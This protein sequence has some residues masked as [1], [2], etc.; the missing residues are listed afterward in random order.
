MK[1]PGLLVAIAVVVILVGGALLKGFG[2]QTT[3]DPT[4]SVDNGAPRGFLALALLLRAQGRTV[5]VV[6][7]FDE[8]VTPAPG[9]VVLV[10]PPEKSA[11]T[12]REA[13]DLLAHVNRGAHVVIACD[14]EEQR[15][16]NLK[17]LAVA[18][19]IECRRAD[20]AIGDEASKRAVAALPGAP[21][22][23]SVRGTGRVRPR[24]GSPAF[25]AWSA[26]A[27]AVVVKRPLGQGSVT[28]L[29]SATIFA[30][31][32]LAHDAN[33]AFAMRELAPSI[34]QEVSA[35]G[36]VTTHTGRVVV[37]E[38]HHR[39][40]SRAA[41]LS[42]AAKGWGPWTALAGLALLVPLSLLMLVPRAGDAPRVEEERRGA[43]A[44]EAQAR[45]LAALLVHASLP[46]ARDGEH[47][48]VDPGAP[49][50]RSSRP[51][52]T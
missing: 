38:R 51:D 14:D 2:D 8:A 18:A 40:R 41:V 44:A 36:T 48:D 26:G 7:T 6:R 24:G 15:N 47:T 27:D 25:P 16:D 3:S 1:R 17:A 5:D 20:V 50:R 33:A 22:P 43:P 31:D 45:A 34:S 37:D 52:V 39:S 13:S 4:A 35:D 46:V 19:G 28:V 42:A 29:G 10:P 9:D 49:R 11:W 23:L 21:E 32:G 30:N 12:E